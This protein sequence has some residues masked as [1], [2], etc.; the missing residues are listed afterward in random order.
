[1]RF[2][3]VLQYFNRGGS[4][5]STTQ[6][7]GCPIHYDTIEDGQNKKYNLLFSNTCTNC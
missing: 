3:V 5:V 4:P 2:F 1:M 7:I 6:N